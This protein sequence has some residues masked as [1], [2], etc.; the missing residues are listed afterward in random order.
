M[1][2]YNVMVH[3]VCVCLQGVFVVD[4]LSAASLGPVS[5]L[6]GSRIIS[7]LSP[8]LSPDSLGR[9]GSITHTSVHGQR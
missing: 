5:G 1:Y 7:S 9:L 8:N 3:C 2:G 4:R 6:T